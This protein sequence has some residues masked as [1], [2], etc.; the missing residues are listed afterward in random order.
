MTT[1]PVRNHNQELLKKLMPGDLVKFP[2]GWYT[3][4]GVYE[5]NNSMIHV[6]GVFEE[7]V[8]KHKAEIKREDFY[9]VC[10]RDK[11]YSGNDMD[12]EW[13]PLKTADIIRRAK[14]NIGQMRY[15]LLFNNCEHFAK[16]C[17]YGRK[18][19]EQV[20]EVFQF[21]EEALIVL[22]VELKTLLKVEMHNESKRLFR[23]ATDRNQTHNLNV[24]RSLKPGDLVK[25]HR[26]LYTHWAVYE[27]D[28]NVIHVEGSFCDDIKRHKVEIKREHFLHVAQGDKAYDGNDMDDDWVAVDT[29]IVLQRAQNSIGHWQ[30]A[31]VFNNCVQFAKWCRYG[32][33][34]KK[35]NRFTCD[36]HV[37]NSDQ[38]N[39]CSLSG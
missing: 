14:A 23:M 4:W 17:R 12:K 20:N 13:E 34:S 9:T 36:Q 31:L 26:S 29:E 39:V 30:Y 33:R 1:D 3:H 19:S 5:G 2:R 18:S 35:Q 21:M 6:A 25:F 38:I 16:W 8:L 37:G 22:T 7:S 32:L 27:G 28:S 15:D 11:A 24:L 10:D